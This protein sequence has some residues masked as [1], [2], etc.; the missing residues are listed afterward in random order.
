M[1]EPNPVAS[2]TEREQL[3]FAL[4]VLRCFTGFGDKPNTDQLWWRTDGRYAPVTFLVNC[5]DTFFWG[6]A[7]CQTL[8][9][10]NVGDLERAIADVR[11][12]LPEGESGGWAAAE[13]FC[14]RMCGMRPQGA[15]YNSLPKATWPLF[16]ACGPERETGLGNPQ[17][18]PAD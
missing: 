13:L 4:R 14:A 2:L 11:A 1:T 8:T 6:C 12:A 16:D 17:A 5:N 9:P 7:D 10:D 18:R 15:V 3:A